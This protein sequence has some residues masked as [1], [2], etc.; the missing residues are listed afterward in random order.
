MT[1]AEREG[2][3]QRIVQF[4]LGVAERRK[5]LV[6]KHFSKEKVPHRTIYNVL[7]R[8]EDTGNVKDKHRS[9][10]P[11]KL[12][13]RSMARL[14]HLVNQKTG[15]SLRQLGSKF[16]VSPETI[17][18]S[19]RG[20]NIHYYKR[21][22]APKYTEKQ[23]QEVPT[24]SRRLYRLLSDQ[25][26]ELVMDDEK[27]FPLSDQTVLSN[28]GYYSSERSEASPNV[29]FKKTQKYEPKILVW[30]AI[31][32]KGIST[33]FF[34]AQRQAINEETYLNDCIIQHLMPFINAHHKKEKV[35]FWPD[36]ASSHYSKSV[37]RYLD[38][39]GIQLVQRNFNPQNCPQARPIETFWSILKNM[40]YERGWEAKTIHELEKRIAEKVTQID[41]T[42]VQSMFSGVRKQ[43]RKIAD[44]GPYRA[45]NY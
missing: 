39:N 22:R 45:C 10:R 7:K 28:R 23:L 4:Y 34:A 2:L 29:K 20:M 8:Y 6:I 31:S 13:R 16:E 41:I 19:L 11:K 33:P 40:V 37:M 44:E 3:N 38:D 24:R 30:I 17:R 43:L 42:V 1:R 21:K 27:Y 14:K 36:L 9:G 25:S 18:Q 32:S 35:L 5:N 12:C 15:V 26:F